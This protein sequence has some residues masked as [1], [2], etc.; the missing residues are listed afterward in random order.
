LLLANADKPL[1]PAVVAILKG[2]TAAQNPGTAAP[3]APPT[4]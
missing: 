1:P 4:K 2:E 3:T